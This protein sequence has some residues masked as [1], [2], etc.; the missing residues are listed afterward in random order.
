MAQINESIEYDK[1]E[2]LEIFIN[3]VQYRKA[4]RYQ[5]RW[6]GTYKIHTKIFNEA[7]ALDDQII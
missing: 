3:M 6:C 1:I 7:G 2:V 4:N 5:K